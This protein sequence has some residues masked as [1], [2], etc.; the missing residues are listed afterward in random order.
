MTDISTTWAVVI[1][2]VKWRV[3]VRWLSEGYPHPEDH[4]KPITDTPGFKPFTIDKKSHVNTNSNVTYFNCDNV[5]LSLLTFAVVVDMDDTDSITMAG[6][7][8]QDFVNNA[9][10]TEEEKGGQNEK[11][12]PRLVPIMLI[13]NKADKVH[14][15]VI[16]DN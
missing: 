10:F 16:L 1:F 5:V 12:D 7:W 9:I 11:M 13:G 15:G 6:T 4:D 3:V 2:R 14:V 8:K